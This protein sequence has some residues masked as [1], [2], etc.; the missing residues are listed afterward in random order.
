M[1]TAVIARVSGCRGWVL[2][3]IDDSASQLPLRT[4]RQYLEG[5]DA[6]RDRSGSPLEDCEPDGW[7]RE[8]LLKAGVVR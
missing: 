8:H 4:P 5:I 7:M 6:Q 3:D 2:E 1:G